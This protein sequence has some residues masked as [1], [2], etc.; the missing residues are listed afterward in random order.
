VV[1]GA[2]HDPVAEDGRSA[3]NLSN[4]QSVAEYALHGSTWRASSRG[5]EVCES[6]PIAGQLVEIRSPNLAAEAAQ[7]AETEIICYDD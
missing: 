3:S 2:G 1:V 6:E 4:D 7:V 5:M